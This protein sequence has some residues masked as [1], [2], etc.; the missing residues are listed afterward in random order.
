[1]SNT[2]WKGVITAAEG[3]DWEQVVMHQG[4][5]C[6]HV[7]HDRR[8]CGRARRWEGHGA[9]DHDFVSLAELLRYWKPA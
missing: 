1:M 9:A 8:F 3:W 5:P 4:E 2:S 7:E 6:F